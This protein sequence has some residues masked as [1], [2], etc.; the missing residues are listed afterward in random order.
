MSQ[1]LQAR[2]NF[3]GGLLMVLAGAGA[4]MAGLGCRTG[5]LGRMGPGVFPVLRAACC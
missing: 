5:T 2:K 4:V 3:I 1:P